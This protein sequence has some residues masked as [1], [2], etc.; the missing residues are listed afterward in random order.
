MRWRITV[1]KTILLG[2]FFAGTG[3]MAQ[4]PDIA[5]KWEGALEAGG[6][7]L[8]LQVDL[9][10]SSDGLYL[11]SFTSIDQGGVKIPIDRITATGSAVHLELKMV[12]GVYDGSVDA[13]GNKMTGTWTQGGPNLPLELTRIGKAPAA[14]APAP[15]VA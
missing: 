13:G 14:P 9:L 1:L 2:A 4:A 12:N 10:R 3:V 6:A 7:K 5:G 11:G 15:A 8:R